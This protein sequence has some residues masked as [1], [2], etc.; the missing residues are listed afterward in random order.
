MNKR[1]KRRSFN[2]K[3]GEY[4]PIRCHMKINQSKNRIKRSAVASGGS[5]DR[6]CEYDTSVNIRNF[7]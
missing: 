7:S 6:Y 3:Q 2:E 1:T 5:H 4:Q